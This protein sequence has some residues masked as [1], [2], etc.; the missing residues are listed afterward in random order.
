MAKTPKP[1]KK[2]ESAVLNTKA[3]VAYLAMSWQRFLILSVLSGG[4]YICYWA[5]KNWQ[6]TA[7]S[8]KEKIMPVFRSYFFEIFFIYPLLQRI[9][10]HL[11]QYQPVSRLF[12]ICSILYV[13]VLLIFLTFSYAAIN[14]NWLIVPRIII[15]LAFA[16][17]FMFIVLL[18]FL[19]LPAQTAINDYKAHAFPQEG[20]KTKLTWGEIVIL[21]TGFSLGYLS[22][23]SFFAASRPLYLTT[24]SQE[25]QVA[26]GQ[27]IGDAYRNIYG[28]A[29]I[30]EEDDMPLKQ[31]PGEF[32]EAMKTEL[33]QLENILARDGLTLDA[34]FQIFLPPQNREIIHQALYNDM[35]MIASSDD[36]GI[37]SACYILEMQAKTIVQSLIKGTQPIYRQTLDSLL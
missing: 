15:L 11:K 22:Y 25:K 20:L 3:P 2:K 13:F 16:V 18:S 7:K 36:S 28:Y 29:V 32:R 10:N 34:A 31:Y 9:K 21:L 14:T 5:Y 1:V 27:L 26:I 35:K 17:N 37:Q 23:A 6:E 8:T 33:E 24:L 30:C 12:K 19:I 4:L